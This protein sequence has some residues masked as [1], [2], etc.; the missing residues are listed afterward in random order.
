MWL[1]LENIIFSEMSDKNSIWDY[2]YL[3]L[4]N[5]TNECTYKTE[6]DSQT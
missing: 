2:L 3:E 5:N 1:D 6:T 4:K